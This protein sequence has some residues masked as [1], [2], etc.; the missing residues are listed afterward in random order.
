MDY[1]ELLKKYMNL[2]GEREGVNYVDTVPNGDSYL[3]L[4]ITQDEAEELRRIDAELESE[5]PFQYPE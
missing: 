3:R 5:L 2:V 1:R 4:P